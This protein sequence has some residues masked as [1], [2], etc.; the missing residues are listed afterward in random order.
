MN[1]LLV[2]LFLLLASCKGISQ[3][4]KTADKIIGLKTAFLQKK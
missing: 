4:E 3:K 1:K 2:L